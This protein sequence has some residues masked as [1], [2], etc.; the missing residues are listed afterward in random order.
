MLETEIKKLTTAIE[1]LTAALQNAPAPVASEVVQ[2]APE[3]SPEPKEE[4]KED[5]GIDYDSLREA[6]KT[7]CLNIMREDRSKKQQVTDILSG[8]GAKTIS[9]A[10]NKDLIG[11]SNELEELL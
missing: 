3:A 9:A 10:N 6:C 1:A 4:P 7:M 2:E 5:K 8:Y 11:I